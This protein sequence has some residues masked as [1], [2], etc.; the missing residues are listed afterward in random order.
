MVGAARRAG[1]MAVSRAE[2][3][4]TAQ[5]WVERTC[6]EQGLRVHVTDPGV[7]ADV[8]ALLGQ[9]RQTGSIRPGS[10]RV[11]PRT[12]GRTTACAR[13]AATIAR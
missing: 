11:R 2:A 10:K 3:P 7:V 12:A 5:A 1:G 9:S 13:T 8:V 4:E 6:A